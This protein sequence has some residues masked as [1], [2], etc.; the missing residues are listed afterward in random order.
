M[1]SYLQIC[2]DVLFGSYASAVEKQTILTYSLYKLVTQFFDP[3]THREQLARKRPEAKIQTLGG[4]VG[5]Y[6]A[7]SIVGPSRVIC[8]SPDLAL[9]SDRSALRSSDP[10]MQK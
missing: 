7:D 5:L 6:C 3:S 1:L 8:I 4:C 10:K 2:C 9:R